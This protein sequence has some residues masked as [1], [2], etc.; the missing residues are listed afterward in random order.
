M[1]PNSAQDSFTPKS[2]NFLVVAEGLE[3]VVVVVVLDLV[4]VVLDL[5]VVVELFV[6]VVDDLVVVV[7]EDVLSKKVGSVHGKIPI[8]KQTNLPGQ[9]LRV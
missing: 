1:L 5:V 3:E 8:I 4:V 7:E 2:L 6:V 9:A